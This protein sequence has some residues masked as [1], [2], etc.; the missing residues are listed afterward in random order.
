M[1]TLTPDLGDA[2]S[3]T[4]LDPSAVERGSLGFVW[5]NCQA[6]SIRR[7][8]APVA[9]DHGVR[10]VRLPPVFEMSSGE[11][12]HLHALL[13]VAGVLV[14]Q[15]VKN[16]YRVPGCGSEQLIGLVSPEARVVTVPTTH[17]E[18]LFP[19][20]VHA[21]DATG[22]GVDAPV[23]DYHDL[24]LL[25]AADRGWDTARAVGRLAETRP[26]PAAVL[27][28]A[29][30]SIAELRRRNAGLDVDTADAVIAAGPDAMWTVNHPSNAVLGAL[31]R[32][33]LSALGWTGEPAVP[34]HEMLGR[35]RTPLSPLVLDGLDM[36]AA[37]ARPTWSVDDEPVGWED[38]AAAALE[39]YRRMPDLAA[40]TVEKYRHRL[41]A[42]RMG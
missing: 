18:G 23:V 28:L 15:P 30:A 4:R 33:V 35:I 27:A 14:T 22:L 16:E 6:E 2:A 8:I 9:A 42:L 7:M 32:G 20:Q 17:Y 5:G 31:G 13:P 3:W 38:V 41:S 11:V 39:L 10:F 34:E 37:A 12:A 21:H 19:W 25:V 24:R 26:D 36:D 40:R 29:E 1:N